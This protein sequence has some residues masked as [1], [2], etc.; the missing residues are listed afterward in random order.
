MIKIGS[1]ELGAKPRVVAVV[2]E[3]IPLGDLT[4]LKRQGVDLLEVRVDLIEMPLDCIVKYLR[5][6][7][8]SVSL[9]MIG[10]VREN[11]RTCKDRI[12]IFKTIIP[13]VDCID[14]ELGTPIAADVLAAATGKTIIVSDHDFEGTPDNAV[15]Q[16][17]VDR[18]V[19]QGAHIVKIVTMAASEEDAWRLLRFAKASATPI[20]AF[21]MGE[22]GSFS[23]VKAC[24]YGSLFTYG[25]STKMV[26]PGQLSAEELVRAVKGRIE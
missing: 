22:A 16:S 2:D 12:A 24:D 17:L 25:Y 4:S 19:R 14:I 21:A 8:L 5:D 7:R 1:C 9:P 20:V 15:L 26:A 6:L 10:T 3:I 23:R 11:E 13:L 18:A